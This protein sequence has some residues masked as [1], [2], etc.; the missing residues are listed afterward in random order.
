MIGDDHRAVIPRQV[1]SFEWHGGFAGE[2]GMAP[3]RREDRN[4]GVVVV[5]P[6]ARF[7]E[8]LDDAQSRAFPHVVDI[9]LVGN[10]DDQNARAGE[11]FTEAAVELVAEA[12]NDVARHARIDFPGEFDKA[13]RDPD[14]R[15]FHVR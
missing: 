13:G 7:V 12:A 1:V 4:V 9:F 3:R 11:A 6:R 2:S 14:S 15:A 10:A 8:Q 5:D